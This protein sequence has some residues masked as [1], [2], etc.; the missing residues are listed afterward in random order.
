MGG[1]YGSMILHTKRCWVGGYLTLTPVRFT[2]VTRSLGGQWT[3]KN[4][5]CLG[6]LRWLLLIRIVR[7]ICDCNECQ[8]SRTLNEKDSFCWLSRFS[9][10]FLYAAYMLYHCLD[11][12]LMR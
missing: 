1:E 10:L 3:G 8:W 6:V 7:D 11:C 4:Y 12:F 2:F 9:W 5:L